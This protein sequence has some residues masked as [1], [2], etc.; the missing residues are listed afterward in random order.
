[1]YTIDKLQKIRNYSDRDTNESLLALYLLKNL[2]DIT[3]ITLTKC[4]HDTGVSKSSVHRFFSNGGYD[5]FKEL[6]EIL[7]KE[8][9]E[10]YESDKSYL[11]H[12]RIYLETSFDKEQIRKL[13]R[14]I[15]EVDR[16][17]FYGKQEEIDK[18]RFL[19]KYLRSKGKT[20][21]CLNIWN[22]NKANEI[23]DSLNKKDLMIIIDT[24]LRIQDLYE[25]SINYSNLIS[26]GDLINKPFHKVFIGD[27]SK[28][29][30]SQFMN[31]KVERNDVIGVDKLDYMLYE[32]LLKGEK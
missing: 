26:I 25:L 11:T 1:M 21:T 27:A 24:S 10:E 18:L 19:M 22:I 3:Q 12:K 9:K 29:Q 31:I 13:V 14:L 28:K 8:M 5:S 30:F 16:V 7:D 15:N 17:C 2:K 6:I 20:Y 32:Y 4:I 23:V